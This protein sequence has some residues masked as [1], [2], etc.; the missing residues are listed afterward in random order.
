MKETLK[1]IQANYNEISDEEVCKILHEH[2][3]KANE[4]AEKKIKEVYAKIGFTL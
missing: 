4:V 1:P 3:K 2:S